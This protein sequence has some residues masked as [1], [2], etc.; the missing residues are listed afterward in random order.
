MANQVYS[1]LPADMIDPQTGKLKLTGWTNVKATLERVK[2]GDTYVVSIQTPSGPK[3]VDVRAASINAP[4]HGPGYTQSDGFD[5]GVKAKQ[6]ATDYFTGGSLT[7]TLSPDVDKYGRALGF[8]KDD[9]QQVPIDAYMLKDGYA[10]Y[11]DG[12]ADK[13]LAGQPGEAAK[14]KQLTADAQKE[15]LGIWANPNPNTNPS[16]WLDQHNA[17]KESAVLQVE[18]SLKTEDKKPIGGL[19]VWR[20][21]RKLTDVSDSAEKF[22]NAWA[23]GVTY[24]EYKIQADGYDL[25]NVPVSRLEQQ[26][27]GAKISKTVT[28]HKKNLSHGVTT[29]FLNGS[30]P[31]AG[32]KVKLDSAEQVTGVDGSIT[33]GDIQDGDRSLRWDAV[34]PLESGAK[35][36]TVSASETEFSIQLS[37]DGDQTSAEIANPGGSEAESARQSTVPLSSLELPSVD[38]EERNLAQDAY[39][40]Y[41]T[42]AQTKMYIGDLFIDEL[43]SIEWSIQENV[44]PVFGFNS[45][46]ADAYAEGRS[47]IQGQIMLNYTAP[48]YLGVALQN[49]LSKDAAAEKESDLNVVQLAYLLMQNKVPANPGDFTPEQLATAKKIASRQFGSTSTGPAVYKRIPFSILLQ[50]GDSQLNRR[51]LRN[52]K[53]TSYNQVVD[54]SGNPN[55]ECYGFIARDAI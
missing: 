39:T 43:V 18:I 54:Q 32:M 48:W 28:L 19:T 52:C 4:E 7:V 1:S 16:T 34:P 25:V 30:E 15:K 46:F 26:V 8:V 53:L 41:F 5:C 11:Y 21:D 23:A 9:N 29:R 35:S 37:K 47:M 2:D 42:S 49:H 45:K 50:F 6:H 36:I 24:A 55:F 33:W 14:Y 10:W 38:P 13:A 51:M 40:G 20:G 3:S 44:V 17:D 27:A 22:I 12:F 31:V